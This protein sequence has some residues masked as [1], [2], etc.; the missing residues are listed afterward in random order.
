[1]VA[2]VAKPR[3]KLAHDVLAIGDSV[4]LAS[5]QAL[6]QRLDGDVTVDAVVGRQVWAGINRLAAYRAAGDLVGLKAVIIDLGTNGPLAPSDVTR[7]RALTVPLPWQA[8]SNASLAAARDLP[9]VE[10]VDWYQASGAPG[11]LWADG[12]HPDPE[13]QVMYA[14]LVADALGG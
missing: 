11:V 13:G 2:T 12:V 6:E 5:A 3:R 1:V 7:L 4:L 9:G 8:E 14:N 10:V